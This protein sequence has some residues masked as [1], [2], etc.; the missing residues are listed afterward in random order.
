[1]LQSW[2]IVRMELL[3][4]LPPLSLLSSPLSPPL[5]L[6]SSLPPLSLLSSLSL[7]S[8]PPFLSSLYL[9]FVLKVCSFSIF[10]YFFS[11]FWANQQKSRANTRKV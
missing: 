1:M 9:I 6:L 7:L 4:L 10:S 8:F 2:Y 11:L 3:S 5:S